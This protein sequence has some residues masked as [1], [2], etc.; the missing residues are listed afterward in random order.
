MHEEPDN[1]GARQAGSVAAIKGSLHG[2]G[3]LH[4]I[5]SCS[6]GQAEAHR[7]VD[8]VTAIWFLANRSQPDIVD[9]QPCQ[10]GREREHRTGR[11]ARVDARISSDTAATHAGRLGMCM[12]G[13]CWLRPGAGL[14]PLETWNE[15][16]LPKRLHDCLCHRSAHLVAK[17]RIQKE[18]SVNEG[19]RRGV[20]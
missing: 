4:P 15:A 16:A 1:T 18:R 12:V 8:I 2:S 6:G 19:S 17:V 10:G 14:H 11:G 3:E 20:A 7:K 9:L 5:A 13:V